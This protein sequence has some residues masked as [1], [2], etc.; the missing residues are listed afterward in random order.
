MLLIILVVIWTKPLW[1]EQVS[2]FVPDAVTDTFDST[3]KFITDTINSDF[4]FEKVT[5]EA[6]SFFA[7]IIESDKGTKQEPVEKPELATPEEQSFSIG[8]VE[9]GDTRDQ[10]EEMYGEPARQSENE[11]G[12]KWSTYHENYQNFMMVSYDEQDVVRG[13]FTNQDLISSKVDIT[14]GDTK[15]YVNET[16]GEPEE[17]IRYGW[18]NYKIESEGEYDV[19]H[20][21][22]SY[23]TIFYDIH[24]ADE[25][26]AIQIIDEDLEA[27]KSA[28][29][30]PGNEALREGLEYQL[31]DLTNATR[32]RYELPVLEW[33]EAV[34]ETA[35]KH[36]TDMAVNNFFNHTNLQGQSP[37][38]RMEADDIS[39]MSAGENLAYGQ[40]S[41]I[42]AHQGLLNSLGHR[43][44]ILQEDFT[45]LGV[46]VDFNESDQPF[47]TENFFSN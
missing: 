33:D 14:L 39:F 12:E 42:F 15:S 30:T 31:F 21:D 27:A 25:V 28:L 45:N 24:E 46:G 23:I 43:E 44:N 40:F 37:F 3:K 47:Y 29:Y 32:V 19:Y 9:L 11:Y 34:R 41:S 22:G 13:L 35:R 7:S 5:E 38:E 6:A 8:N 10:V 26:T 16:L 4:H 17:M 1:E 2:E 20:M 36:S 18:F